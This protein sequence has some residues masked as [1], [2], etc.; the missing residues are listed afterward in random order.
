MKVVFWLS[1]VPG[2]MGLYSSGDLWRREVTTGQL[3]GTGD[4]VYLWPDDEDGDIGGPRL[5]ARRR[6]MAASGQWHV[7][8]TKIVVD[9]PERERETIMRES[10]G[11]RQD[12]MCWWTD[13]E[14]G[15]PDEQ[16][17][18]AAGWVKQ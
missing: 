16:K 10:A 17:L 6:Y 8:L 18:T 9:P 5:E 11:G 2:R 15:P 4:G 3:P 12:F 1:I 7:E 14:G 13:S